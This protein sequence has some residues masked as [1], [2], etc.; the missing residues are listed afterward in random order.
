MNTCKLG[1]EPIT[2][3]PTYAG[4]AATPSRTNNATGACTPSAL[5]SERN[6]DHG[7]NRSH[8]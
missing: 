3:P 5:T 1:G 8:D 2:P 7:I 6:P 4:I